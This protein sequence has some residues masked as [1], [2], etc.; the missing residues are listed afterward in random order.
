[1]I[2]PSK[3]QPKRPSKRP[4]TSQFDSGPST[5]RSTDVADMGHDIKTQSKLVV[6]DDK[7][8]KKETVTIYAGTPDNVVPTAQE[9][10]FRL[11][12]IAPESGPEELIAAAAE[13]NDNGSTDVPSPR[14]EPKSKVCSLIFNLC[15]Y[16]EVFF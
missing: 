10:V 12:N 11:R 3:R 14:V 8:V 4:M 9:H 16:A 1:M 2:S 5:S 7:S 15:Y 13:V 6:L